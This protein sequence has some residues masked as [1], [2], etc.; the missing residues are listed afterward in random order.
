VA[1]GIALLVILAIDGPIAWQQRP[2]VLAGLADETAHLLTAALLLA[3]VPLALPRA[4]VISALLGSML[5][6]LDHLPLIMGSDLLTR[7]TGRPVTHS[8]LALGC[9]AVIALWLPPWSKCLGWG[10]AA[11]IAAHFVRDLA[12][13]SA[14]VPLFWPVTPYGFTLAHDAYFALLVV[15]LAAVWRNAWADRRDVGS[16]TN[17][18]TRPWCRPH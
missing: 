15:C 1:S 8:M 5:I 14:G 12:S 10:L 6:D 9:A 17:R 18:K 11:G 7:E 2:L 3:A 13:T 4:F 16:T